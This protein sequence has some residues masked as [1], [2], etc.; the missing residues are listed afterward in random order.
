V[1]RTSKRPEPEN[2]VH[3]P[4]CDRHEP[5]CYSR[6]H[7]PTPKSTLRGNP[8]CAVGPKTPTRA[9]SSAP[10][11]SIFF[12]LLSA[13]GSHSARLCSLRDMLFSPWLEIRGRA[14]PIHGAAAPP[15]V[16]PLEQQPRQLRSLAAPCFA[17]S[18]GQH[19]PLP[20]LRLKHAQPYTA[21][22]LAA[23]I[24]PHSPATLALRGCS[25]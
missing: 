25:M 9:P 21:Q 15:S 16:P 18:S 12:L 19:H 22:L 3:C 5:F 23:E 7:R 13:A 20:P 24:F 2:L 11:C 10:P 4:S 8:G 6:R 17:Q 1:L 14:S